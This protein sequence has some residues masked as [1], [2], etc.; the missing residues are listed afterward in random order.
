MTFN[1]PR[2]SFMTLQVPDYGEGAQPPINPRNLESISVTEELGKAPSGSV[3]LNDPSLLYDRVLRPNATCLMSWGYK[4]NGAPVE[5]LFGQGQAD[6]YTKAL[7]RRGLKVM[8]LNPAGSGEEN[9][10]ST[11]TCGM[12]SVGWFGD[13]KFTTYDSG[14]K[15][16]VVRAA[17]ARMG[18]V[19]DGV[20]VFV[21]FDSSTD[22]YSSESVERQSETDFEFLARLS[23]EWRCLFRVGY[24]QS[25]QP[26]AAFFE[27]KY[28]QDSIAFFS[29]LMG[30]APV[31]PSISWKNGDSGDLLCSS[32][33]WRNEMGDNGEGDNVQFSLVNGQ[34]TF[35]RFT[36]Q[37]DVV[38][39]QKL[40]E[41]AVADYV[42]SGG[43]ISPVLDA[44]S[45][46]DP[47]IQRF[48]TT[49][50]QMT[51]PNGL[52]YTVNVHMLGQPF[53][54]AGMMMRL[55][56]GFPPSLRLSGSASDPVWFIVKKATHMLDLGGYFTDLE[57]VDMFTFSP[58]M[59]Y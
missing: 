24:D 14:T 36:V 8:V 41:Q 35:R 44:R 55:N 50:K 43:A 39:V 32:Y 47:N 22:S 51:A 25:G 28:A 45:F 26:W 38:T 57:C 40:D 48:W 16:D 19:D 18:C 42:N 31:I 5:S 17:M 4:A 34:P 6:A 1:A 2:N 58:I 30:M 59:V 3:R 10:K 15:L 21:R 11:F 33:S 37:G 29:S 23:F 12:L 46:K 49:V 56:R 7:E 54:T 13:P 20:H 53:L 27:S 9:G 52:G